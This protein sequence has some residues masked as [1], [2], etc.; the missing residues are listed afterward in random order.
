MYQE[1]TFSLL[2]S[3]WNHE[4]LCSQWLQCSIYL[5]HM[6][7]W[8]IQG[9]NNKTT[10][11]PFFS[12][13]H[14]ISW[15]SDCQKRWKVDISA[16]MMIQCSA[17]PGGQRVCSVSLSSGQIE[18]TQWCWMGCDTPFGRYFRFL[19]GSTQM[20]VSVYSEEPRES[21]CGE[22][23]MREAQLLSKVSLIKSW[24]ITLRLCNLVFLVQRHLRWAVR[25]APL[26]PS[27]VISNHYS[28]IP[29][30]SVNIK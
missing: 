16:K 5:Q 10:R 20:K 23:Q 29:A 11:K 27:L 30:L 13:C 14:K 9:K 26:T 24:S 25:S 4:L 12:L 2:S 3:I 8:I 18:C 21:N 19:S 6:K 17:V 7:G 22:N 15:Q 28:H 1:E